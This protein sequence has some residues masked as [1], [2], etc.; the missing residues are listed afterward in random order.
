MLLEVANNDGEDDDGDEEAGNEREGGGAEDERHIGPWRRPAHPPQQPAVA[1]PLLAPPNSE[2]PLSHVADSTTNGLAPLSAPTSLPPSHELPL[3]AASTSCPAA[4]S[5]SPASPPPP[6]PAALVLASPALAPSPEA[7]TA[8]GGVHDAVAPGAVARPMA[9]GAG[10]DEDP[11][12][13]NANQ[14]LIHVHVL[15]HKF[16][17][18]GHAFIVASYIAC[19]VVRSQRHRVLVASSV[20]PVSFSTPSFSRART[21]SPVVR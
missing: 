13:P 7:A 19:L 14:A 9:A 8:G 20:T 11:E 17:L 10:G 15:G 4:A 5:P 18:T 1:G 6:P 16:T 21:F 12:V 3:A 2:P